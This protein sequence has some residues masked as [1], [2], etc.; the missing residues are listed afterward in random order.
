M[1][2]GLIYMEL[3]KQGRG[4]ERMGVLETET[5]PMDRPDGEP[6]ALAI[7]GAGGY[8]ASITDLVLRTGSS[9]QPAV[10][11][12]GVAEPDTVTHARR[13]EELRQRGIVTA[14]SLDELLTGVSCDAV[15]LPLPIPL[16]R[17]LTERALVG[18]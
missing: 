10:R 6:V 17:P 12:V 13:L 4:F 8:A 16:H 11:L 9:C 18:G 14:P 3:R 5:K 2:D 7:A 1:A 15:W